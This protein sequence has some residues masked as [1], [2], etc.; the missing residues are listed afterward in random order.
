MRQK[1]LKCRLNYIWNRT[2][3]RRRIRTVRAKLRLVVIYY[4][5]GRAQELP[6]CN[7]NGPGGW[8]FWHCGSLVGGS[9]PA[10]VIFTNTIIELRLHSH[11]HVIWAHALP[12]IADFK[13]RPKVQVNAWHGHT[14]LEKREMT[15]FWSFLS[16]KKRN[17][18]SVLTVYSSNL[19]E[20][21][22]FVIRGDTAFWP[23]SRQL[24]QLTSNYAINSTVI[25]RKH[26][27]IIRNGVGE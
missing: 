14:K 11:T 16:K 4:R 20:I 26:R 7:G 9:N 2:R 22:C 21:N 18:S 25:N 12:S 1:F 24:T 17:E 19:N 3:G 6:W 27:T 23:R 10:F 15:K 8:E 13:H 5:E